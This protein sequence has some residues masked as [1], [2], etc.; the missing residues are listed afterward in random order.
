M[1]K[2]SFFLISL[3]LIT[4]AANAFPYEETAA[5]YYGRQMKS[6]EIYEPRTSVWDYFAATRVHH[7]DECCVDSVK[8]MQAANAKRIAADKN[9]PQGALKKSLSCATSKHWC[10]GAK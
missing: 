4:T 9:C 7:F 2:Y 6:C 5:S 10:E 8:A 1:F 3:L